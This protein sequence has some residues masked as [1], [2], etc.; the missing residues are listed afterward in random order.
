MDIKLENIFLDSNANWFLG[1]FGSTIPV[2]TRI[3]SITSCLYPTDIY[4]KTRSSFHFDWFGVSVCL[5]MI[6]CGE[7]WHNLL[8]DDGKVSGD[9]VAS[10]IEIIDDQELKS[11]IARLVSY[12][13]EAFY[14]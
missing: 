2:N 6:W 1:D 9:K 8:F 12:N 5:L 4:E 10:C 11:L 14:L 13:E 3:K 7:R